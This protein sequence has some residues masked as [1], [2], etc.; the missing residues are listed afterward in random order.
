MKKTLILAVAA[1]IMLTFATVSVSAKDI[2]AG[3]RME[4]VS[5]DE[6]DNDFEVFTYKD[7]D[8]TF[9]YYL[10][11]G[12]VYRVFDTLGIEVLGINSFDITSEVC[13][14]LGSTKDEA[15]AAL[16]FLIAF[17]DK[18]VNT[19]TGFPARMSLGVERLGAPTTVDCVVKKKFLRGKYLQFHFVCDDHKGEADLTKSVVKFL[20]TGVKRSK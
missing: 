20:R 11:L 16:D 12:H 17:F 4:I 5:A 3:V 8:G 19:V 15:L 13:I 7:D 14:C 18:D 2:P 1:M 6:D 9:G 10:G